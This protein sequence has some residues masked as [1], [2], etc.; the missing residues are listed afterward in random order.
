MG[1]KVRSYYVKEIRKKLIV[2]QHCIVY[3]STRN[4]NPM[5]IG[6]SNFHFIINSSTKI[7]RVSSR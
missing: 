4:H 5:H 3:V 6:D 1:Y 7:R 2:S